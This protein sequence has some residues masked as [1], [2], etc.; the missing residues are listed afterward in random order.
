TE[1]HCCIVFMPGTVELCHPDAGA[2]PSFARAVYAGD[3]CPTQHHLR[4]VFHTAY[5]TTPMQ[6]RRWKYETFPTMVKQ[7]DLLLFDHDPELAGG[8]LQTHPQLEVTPSHTLSQFEP[9]PRPT[10]HLRQHTSNAGL[11]PC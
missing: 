6:T 2:L 11:T 5:D 10:R 4:L 3:V 8:L 1:G 9:P 7:R